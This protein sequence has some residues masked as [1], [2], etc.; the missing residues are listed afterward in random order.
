MP[1]EYAKATVSYNFGHYSAD[2]LLK[3]TLIIS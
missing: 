3:T 1:G 2:A